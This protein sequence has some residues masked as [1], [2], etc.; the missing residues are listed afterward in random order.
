MS[1]NDLFYS[2]MQRISCAR[3]ADLAQPQSKARADGSEKIVEQVLVTAKGLT[4][5]AALLRPSVRAA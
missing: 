1:W 3:H 2:E 5:L 4:K